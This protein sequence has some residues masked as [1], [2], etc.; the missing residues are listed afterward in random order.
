[1]QYLIGIGGIALILAIAYAFSSNRG[2]IRPRV[3][4]AAFAL[5]AAIAVIV[6]YT[7]WGIAAIKAMSDG[8]VALLG[9]ANAGTRFRRRF[10]R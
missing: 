7:P 5:Q 8:V 6:L 3:V 2:W 9:Y 10:V 4:L 1:M